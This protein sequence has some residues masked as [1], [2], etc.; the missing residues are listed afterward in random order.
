VAKPSLILADE[1]TGNLD[2]QT[3]DEIMALFQK[4]N[5]EGITLV[6]VTHE[7]DVAT[8]A[9]RLT[10]F[11]DGLLVEDGPVANRRRA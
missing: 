1:P 3:S 8:Y 6:L 2:T 7:P 5:D 9:K 4:L 10:K 11:R